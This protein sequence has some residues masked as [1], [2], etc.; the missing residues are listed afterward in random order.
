MDPTRPGPTAFFREVLIKQRSSALHIA[1][2]LLRR[3]VDVTIDE[4][5]PILS[6][7]EPRGKGLL[8]LARLSFRFMGLGLGQE[9]F[10][11]DLTQILPLE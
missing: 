10:P 6:A 4:L 8:S 1:I 5:S 11:L 9:A 2:V 7:P 3:L